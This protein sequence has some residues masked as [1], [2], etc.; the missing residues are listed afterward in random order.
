MNIVEWKFGNILVSCGWISMA[1]GSIATL[2]TSNRLFYI[3]I[4]LGLILI[5]LG[6]VVK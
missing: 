2:L 6:Y 1:I 5:F 3:P 4:G